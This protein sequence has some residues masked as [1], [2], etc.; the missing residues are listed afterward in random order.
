MELSWAHARWEEKRAADETPEELVIGV[1]GSHANVAASSALRD[2]GGVL[3]LSVFVIGV[4]A[5]R[6]SNVVG[7]AV[8]KRVVISDA[9]Q[10]VGVGVIAIRNLTLADIAKDFSG[11]AIGD[12]G[13]EGAVAGRVGSEE[14]V[15]E[16]GFAVDVVVRR[17]RVE[18]C[19]PVRVRVHVAVVCAL[20]CLDG[21][22]VARCVV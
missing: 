12:V 1:V 13:K 2:V 7:E 19:A 17:V 4:L 14:A 15:V 8:I 3:S 20:V 11:N 6:K 16:A 22:R 10:L 5:P 9:R 21:E 18:D